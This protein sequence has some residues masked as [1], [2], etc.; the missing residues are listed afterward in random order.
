MTSP[1]ILVADEQPAVVDLL[2]TVLTFHGFAVDTA[3]T[4]AQAVAHTTVHRP[5]L[6][7]LDVMLS[8]GAGVD[9]ARRL[10]AGGSRADV[11]FLTARDAPADLVARVAYGGN[12]WITKPVDLGVLLARVRGLAHRP[13]AAPQ[14]RTLRHADVELDEDTL[15]VRR[16]GAPVRLSPAEAGLLRHFLRNPGRVLPRIELGEAVR[17]HGGT[18]TDAVDAYVGSLRHK[19]DRLGPP[20]IVTHRGFGYALRAG[21]R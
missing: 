9:V 3:A 12:D 20:L 14:A 11:V 19:L 7:L 18:G 10:R 5:D 1:R 6:V 15:R 8:G 4:A 16:A 2:S 17:G 21:L 13:G